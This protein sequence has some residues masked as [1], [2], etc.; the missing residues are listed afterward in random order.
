VV[1]GTIMQIKLKI[2]KCGKS[3]RI[4]LNYDFLGA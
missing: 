3:C 4:Y 2:K 1:P